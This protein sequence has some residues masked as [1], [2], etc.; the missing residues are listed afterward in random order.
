MRA[1]DRLLNVSL[2]ASCSS[3]ASSSSREVKS[4]SIW[5]GMQFSGLALVRQEAQ[6]PALKKKGGGLTQTEYCSI[7]FK[8]HYNL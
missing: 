6:F 7:L 1:H 8:K 4:D 3:I 2:Q 5:A